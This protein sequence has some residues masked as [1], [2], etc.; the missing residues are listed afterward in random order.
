LLKVLIH[1]SC[2]TQNMPLW[3]KQEFG[4]SGGRLVP[5]RRGRRGGPA[6][7]TLGMF[8]GVW[9]LITR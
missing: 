7:A 4:S 6:E 3:F 9:E 1:F 2:E 5:G 8:T